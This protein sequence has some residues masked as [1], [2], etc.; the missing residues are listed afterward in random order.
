MANFCNLRDIC[1]NNDNIFNMK[2]YERIYHPYWLWEDYKNGFNEN[3][4]GEIKINY[5]EKII[6]MFNSEQKTLENMR[7]VINNWTYSCEHNLTNNSVNKIAYLGQCACCFYC[8]APNTIT[9]ECWS[10]LT[11]EV[12]VRANKNAEQV[13]SEWKINNK[14][15][16]LCLNLD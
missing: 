4:S 2:E 6:E 1:N 9:M 13:L 3:C 15:I 11:N 16:Q 10:M 8:G 5:K 7:N 12:K 14:Y